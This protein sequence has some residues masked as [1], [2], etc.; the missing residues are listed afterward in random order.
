MRAADWVAAV[1]AVTLVAVAA[2]LAGALV[3]V[4]R[5]LRALRATLAALRAE[6]ETLL[7]E[8]RRVVRE[9]RHDVEQ[10]DALL[11][12]AGAVSDRMDRASRLVSRTVTSPVVRVMALGAGTR[13]AVQRIRE[14]PGTG[15]RR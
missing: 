4:I 8:T 6:T 1:A 9:A 11:E 3:S 14:Q 7:A 15:R 12:T 2:V 13:R 10:L 5:T